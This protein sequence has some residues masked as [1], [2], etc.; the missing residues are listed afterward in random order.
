MESSA[1]LSGLLVFAGYLLSSACAGGTFWYTSGRGGSS[2]YP[3]CFCQCCGIFPTLGWGKRCGNGCVLRTSGAEKNSAL[4]GWGGQAQGFSLPTARR[5]PMWAGGDVGR[6]SGCCRTRL[7]AA[8]RLFVGQGQRARELPP[9]VNLPPAN[10]FCTVSA[11][12]K[13]TVSIFCQLQLTWDFGGPSD[14]ISSVM[15]QEQNRQIPVERR[16]EKEFIANQNNNNSA[17]TSVATGPRER[18]AFPAIAPL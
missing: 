7:R 5:V 3:I 10:P 14:R 8:G 11:V 18:G 16:E 15:S 4:G 2:F 6:P 13:G 9:V 1:A 17:C 12:Q